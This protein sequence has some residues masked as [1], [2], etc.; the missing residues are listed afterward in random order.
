M[1]YTPRLPEKND[2]VSETSG[3]RELAVL[4]GGLLG[5][6][7]GVYFLLGLAVDWVAP[8]VSPK[9][10]RVLG[11]NLIHRFLDEETPD[12]AT[13]ALREL[14]DRVSAGCVDLPYD[15][16]V[17]LSRED[18]VNAAAL[19][20]GHIVVFAGLIGQLDSE[21]ELAFVLL[22]EM[23]HFANRDHLRGL[24][25]ALVLSVISAAILGPDNPISS[26]LSGGF[27]LTELHFSREQ[28][29]AADEYA[30]RA[31][32]C[33]YGHVA[34]ADGFFV[35]LKEEEG[36]ADRMTAYLRT[37]PLSGDRVE[38]IAE[39]AR[40]KEYVVEARQNPLPAALR[41]VPENQE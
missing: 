18:V 32:N 37:H 3:L 31:L 27:R 28:E 33:A 41:S 2:N 35:E 29:M 13:R 9:L 4:L 30:V 22:H 23:G 20:G 16:Q 36:R 26:I 40:E 1:K 38:H 15:I 7:V 21:N 24:G 19:P 11:A 10:E 6:V 14:A 5:I 8:H 34:G 25:R 12:E 39:Y 17:H